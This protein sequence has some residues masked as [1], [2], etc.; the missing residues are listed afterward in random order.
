M[1]THQ[2]QST[3][4]RTSIADFDAITAAIRLYI[5]GVAE[6]DTAKLAEAFRP[7]ARMYGA[8]GSQRYDMPINEFFEHVAEHP[9]DVDGTFAA[10]ITSIVHAG[11]AAGAV[12]VEE[13]HL[14]TLTFVDYLTLCRSDGRWRIA[15]KTFAHTAGEMP[16]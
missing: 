16:Q 13:N 4:G 1:A 9:A 10:R 6:G 12:V 3:D 14:G 15:N 7:D 8:I 11:D 5:D 2:Q